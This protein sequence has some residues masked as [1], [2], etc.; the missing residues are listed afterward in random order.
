MTYV[1]WKALYWRPPREPAIWRDNHWYH[2][3]RY[4]SD[5]KRYTA[6]YRLELLLL[7]V[8]YSCCNILK[9]IIVIN[10]LVPVDGTKLLLAVAVFSGAVNGSG[11]T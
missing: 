7:S 2:T 5:H 4:E 6:K 3:D 8:L 9:L 10:V 11:T 1:E